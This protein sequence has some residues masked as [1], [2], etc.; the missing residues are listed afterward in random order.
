MA[1]VSRRSNRASSAGF[2]P[3][4]FP[5][6]GRNWD[7]LS[8]PRRCRVFLNDS[9]WSVT[10]RALMLGST[11]MAGLDAARPR[12]LARAVLAAHA[13]TD[14]HGEW[15]EDWAVVWADAGA[16]QPLPAD[17][18]LFTDRQKVDQAVLG[19]LLRLNQER[20]TE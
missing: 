19:N 16:G 6:R 11:I 5:Q 18:P 1:G 13:A 7:G 20:R 15:S 17:H 10:M 2:P 9:P 12:K 8:G 3:R 4:G 14:P